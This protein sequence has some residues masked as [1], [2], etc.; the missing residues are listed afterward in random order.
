MKG[1]KSSWV[2]STTAT[3]TISGTS[4]VSLLVARVAIAGIA[5]SS[6]IPTPAY[7]S[8]RYKINVT[9]VAQDG[10]STKHWTLQCNPTGGTHKGA[11]KAC[12]ALL[13]VKDP[14]KSSDPNRICTEQYGGPETANVQGIW[15]GKKIRANFSKINGCEIARWQ[16]VQALLINK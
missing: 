7:A 9:Y 4:M 6:V 3:N 16:K 11:K 12:V 14:F 2:G 8:L 5:L 1:I 10:A 13:K 15:N